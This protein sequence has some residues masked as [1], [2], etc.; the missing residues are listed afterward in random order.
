MEIETPNI[1]LNILG[2]IIQIVVMI[3]GM[4]TGYQAIKSDLKNALDQ[5]IRNELEL[6][7]IRIQLLTMD[8]ATVATG[9]D[10]KDL[11]STYE[12]DFDTYIRSH[13]GY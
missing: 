1:N 5:G 4:A 13:K 6:K 11:H 9:Q 3:I 12:R 7:D 10:L 8:K 2:F